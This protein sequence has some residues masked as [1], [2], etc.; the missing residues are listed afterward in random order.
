MEIITV[1]HV[2]LDI[3]MMVRTC[4]SLNN[5]QW[6]CCIHSLSPFVLNSDLENDIL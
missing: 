5:V 2:L 1:Y 3:N 6:F 4:D